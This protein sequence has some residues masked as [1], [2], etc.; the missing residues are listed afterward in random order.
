MKRFRIEFIYDDFS[1]RV[2]EIRE[3]VLYE[4][5]DSRYIMKLSHL[6]RVLSLLKA[7]RGSAITYEE[8]EVLLMRLCPRIKVEY[9]S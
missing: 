7:V 9:D 2:D 1:I 4:F 6:N 8:Y 5:Q 3:Y